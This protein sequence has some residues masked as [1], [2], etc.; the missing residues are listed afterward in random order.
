MADYEKTVSIIFGGTDNVSPAAKN[1]QQGMN[2]LDKTI[3]NISGPLASTAEGILKIDTALAALV[4]GGLAYAVREAGNFNGKFGE[5]STLITDTGAPIAKFKADIKDY[6]VSSVKSIDEINQSIYTAVSAGVDYKDSIKFVNE[7]EKLSVAG[8]SAL[9]DT[10]KVLISTLNAYGESTNAAGKYSDMMFAT[11]KG[12]LTTMTELSASLSQVTGLAANSGIPFQTLSAAIAALTTTGMPTAEAIT[13]IKA[14][15]SNIIKPT[16]EAEQMAASLGLQFNATALKTKGFETVLW[17]AYKA[18]GG[19]TEKMAQLF[20]SVEALN[21]VLVLAS[22][23]TGKFKSS[24]EA[25]SKSAGATQ[26]AYDKVANE[27]ANINTRLL[28]SFKITLGELGEKIL[29]EYGKIAGGLGDLFK[30]IKVGVDQ[31]AFDPL[32]NYFDLVGG[33]IGAWLAQWAK[34]LPESLKLVNW[35]PIVNSLGGLVDDISG[36]FSDKTDTPEK[37]AAAIQRVVDTIGTLIDL[38]KGIGEPF[39]PFLD[40]VTAVADAFNSLDSGTKTLI[41]N[42]MGLALE[43]KLFGPAVTA[44]M[45]ILGTD[46]R[47]GANDARLAFAALENGINVLKVGVIALGLGFANAFLDMAEFLN[48]IPGVDM[49][50]GIARNTTRVTEL[51][52]AL[53]EAETDMIKS[54][55]TL[56]D[57][58]NRLPPAI[59]NAKSSQDGWNKKVSDSNAVYVQSGDTMESLGKKIAVMVGHSDAATTSTGKLTDAITKLPDSKE[60]KIGVQADGV[61]IEKAYGMIIERFP[62]GAVRIVQAQATLDALSAKNVQAK[63]EEYVPKEKLV[64][65]KAKLDEAKIKASSEVIQKSLEWKAKINMA[66]V[67]A[68]TQKFLG[69][70]RSIDNTVTS[71]GQTLSGI[72]DSYVRATSGEK[73]YA[74]ETEIR[75]ESARRD[76]A[77]ADQHLMVVEEVNLLKEKTAA[78][79]RGDAMIT[80]NGA[81]LQPHLEAFM[82]EIL[83]A[84]QVKANAEGMK[85]LVGI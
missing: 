57:T 15:I 50:D 32:F 29:P 35:T 40:G 28:N 42:V 41:G 37:F 19:S 51:S 12:G 48:K 26:V 36:I 44:S 17:D 80:I 8:R 85:M 55:G 67:E 5:I 7:A 11:V 23:K 63:L 30:G 52:K 34:L 72:F 45:L 18:T 49:S 65:I 16:A 66:E 10:T 39:G 70:V 14:A 47:A 25:I 84:I 6:A 27:L 76:A 1:V 58:W 62:D 22:D 59:D 13:S 71:T 24:L 79:K 20:G 78:M 69:I 77:L 73:Q 64:E 4:V 38:T 53:N 60:I 21:G 54:T 33:S 31:G 43:Y 2:G 3:Q 68:D 81:G 46:S 75:K 9:G 74:I 61:T 82:F 83:A 56:A